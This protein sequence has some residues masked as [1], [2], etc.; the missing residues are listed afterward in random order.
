M[1]IRNWGGA[2]RADPPKRPNERL[3]G[4]LLPMPTNKNG[5]FGTPGELTLPYDVLHDANKQGGVAILVS[6]VTLPSEMASRDKA[7]T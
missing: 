1:A 6:R 7:Q 4:N 3:T 2:M 5:F